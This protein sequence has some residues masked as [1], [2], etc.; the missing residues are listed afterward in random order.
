M[1]FP[2][3]LG[4]TSKVNLLTLA[5]RLLASAIDCSSPKALRF[6]IVTLRIILSCHPRGSLI[7]NQH[8]KISAVVATPIKKMM[9]IAVQ[10]TM[11]EPAAPYNILTRG[12]G[13][14]GAVSSVTAHTSASTRSGEMLSESP[15]TP[16][17]HIWSSSSANGGSTCLTRPC[18]YIAATGSARTHLPRVACTVFSG[19]L[20]STWRSTARTIS[21]P[22]FTSATSVSASCRR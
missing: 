16:K 4:P 10:V 19:T 9:R 3:L 22:W 15:L 8:H 20:A 1:L 2:E 17:S 18:A 11:S 6:A 21:P 12:C 13:R 5:S 14:A 7:A